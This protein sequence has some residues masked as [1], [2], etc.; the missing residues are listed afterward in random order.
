MRGPTY[1]A[2]AWLRAHRGRALLV[3]LCVALTLLLPVAVSVF[4]RGYARDLAE[5]ARRTPLIVGAKGSRY[6]LVLSTLHFRGRL[7]SPTT[8]AEL[9]RSTAGDLQAPVATAGD[10]GQAIPLHV[11]STARGLPVVGTTPDYHRL[12]G[13]HAA[14]GTLPLRLGEAAL[15]AEAAR[16]LGLDVGGSVLTDERG[17]FQFGLRQ[18]LRLRLVGVLAPTG[19]PD[20]RA[21]FVDLKTAW[22]IDGLGH[23]HGGPAEI[24]P[25]QVLGRDPERG[26]VMGAGVKEATEITPENEASFHV[27]GDPATFPLTSFL[28]LPVD[29]KAA[30]ILKGR[31]R[32]SETAQMLEPPEVVEEL[33]GLVFKV[34]AFFDANVLLVSVATGLLLG[35][36]VLLTLR[37]RRREFETLARIGC[38]RG[39]LVR[40]VLTE[41]LVLVVLG[42]GLAALLGSTLL[43]VLLTDLLP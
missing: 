7:P 14:R 36:V 2:L 39:T 42:V 26:T 6:D 20:D 43:R 11:A 17:L 3:V 38:G 8:W 33:L 28:V 31:Y 9:E 35:L 13:L 4:V 21:V 41:W 30:T 24:D 25:S 27:H 19:T 34:K 15:G 22:V 29:D 1:L 10:L 32:L 23:L 16:S 40:I 12:R 5:R 18:P 37:V